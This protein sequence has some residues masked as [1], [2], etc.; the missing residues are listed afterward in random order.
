[1]R[2][3]N[4]ARAK[5]YL[6]GGCSKTM[7]CDEGSTTVR[8]EECRL[9]RQ[10]SR[11][12]FEHRSRKAFRF[13]RRRRRR[14]KSAASKASTAMEA[15]VLKM[16]EPERRRVERRAT[17]SNSMGAVKR[18]MKAYN[19]RALKNVAKTR[20]RDYSKVQTRL[21]RD[22]WRSFLPCTCARKLCLCTDLRSS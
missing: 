7:P 13:G 16:S 9:L 19:A 20:R 3:L 14:G 11:S 5:T 12:A 21:R 17:P 4:A 18:V 8:R 2:F 6:V 22:L 10:S 15:Q 1:M